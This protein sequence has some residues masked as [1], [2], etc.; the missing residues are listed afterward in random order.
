MD[1]SKIKPYADLR[2][3]SLNERAKIMERDYI[4]IT[5]GVI[6]GAIGLILCPLPA[7]L[8]IIGATIATSILTRWNERYKRYYTKPG[9]K[10]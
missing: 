1:K 3:G 8:G 7:L 5:G 6:L 4:K 9:R 2:R 10:K